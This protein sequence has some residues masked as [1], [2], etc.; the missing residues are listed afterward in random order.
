M[1]PHRQRRW[2]LYALSLLCASLIAVVLSRAVSWYDHP[3]ADVL[4][5]PGGLVS[6]I[7]LPTAEGMKSGLSFPDAVLRVDGRPLAAGPG[8]TLVATWDDA[9]VE[10]FHSGRSRID[11]TV[12]T[13]SGERTV[14]LNV[15]P[16]EPL[17]WWLY[18]GAM[19][20]A[21]ALYFAAAL[22][23]LWASPDSALARTFGKAGI[24]S[25]VLLALT[26]DFHTTR[27]LSPL[28]FVA[29]AFVPVSWLALS[30]RL[31]DDAPVLVRF[32]W[33]ERAIDG[34]GLAVATT[35]L[36]LYFGH[37]QTRLL[38]YAW[39]RAF[40]VAFAITGLVLLTRFV[41]ARGVR[42]HRLRALLLSVASPHLAV[43]LMVFP[44]LRGDGQTILSFGTLSLFPLATAYAF[45]RYD[46]WGSRRLLSRILTRI[47]VGLVACS[48]AILAA[49]ALAAQVGVAF[50]G[51][52]LAAGLGAAL[53][54]VLV[55]T[56]LRFVDR[57]FF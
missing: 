3:V 33:L 43:G 21:G 19:L 34:L 54:T 13:R 29:F 20:F 9:V 15:R 52:L 24:S 47:A 35:F 41:L 44:A 25:G 57:S 6:N 22:I 11:A 5:D 48:I 45:I 50:G 30:L 4:V 28:F 10:A 38:Q 26:F 36:I 17:R 31:P 27:S 2:P 42:R 46:L 53:G 23:A 56:A 14:E 55:L 18:A 51:A 12:L 1:A 49:T 7:G 39:S 8:R 32:P 16:L 40:G 37:H